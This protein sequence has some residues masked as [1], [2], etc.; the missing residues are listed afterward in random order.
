MAVVG[1][2]NGMTNGDGSS[3][4]ARIISV[5][6]GKGGV[7]KTTLVSN[8]SIL[9]SRKFQKRVLAI[10]A[11]ITT[12]NLGLHMGLQSTPATL[13]DV[14]DGG[15]PVKNAIYHIYGIDVIPAAH[16]IGDEKM[17]E[18]LRSKIEPLVQD[19]DFILLDSSPGLG[20]EARYALGA[21]DELLL[22]TNP[23]ISAV[24]QVIKMV[25]FAE[26]AGMHVTGVVLNRRAGKEWEIKESEVGENCGKRVM[27]TIP[28]DTRVQK[29]IAI[30]IPVVVSNPKSKAAKALESLA[31]RLV[32]VETQSSVIGLL[33]RIT[34]AVSAMKG[35]ILGVIGGGGE[36]P[37]TSEI[38]IAIGKSE[39]NG[40][41]D[42][43]AEVIA[44]AA[45]EKQELLKEELLDEA[46]KLKP[47][48]EDAKEEADALPGK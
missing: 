19:Y 13:H 42:E 10:D 22:V 44:K 9:L 47:V 41:D 12:A 11:N 17:L 16:S 34:F 37:S 43:L 45:E 27:A 4:R 46:E 39:V 14:L 38:P 29:S 8:L 31:G 33:E 6:S 30:R 25:R 15:V 48:P 20:M 26:K 3:G 7:G 23:E 32:G 21:A 28:E 2:T 40:D 18:R 35:L 24:T 5:I 36:K 1:M